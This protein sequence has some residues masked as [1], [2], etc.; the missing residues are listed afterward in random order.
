MSDPGRRR[1]F[2]FVILGLLSAVG[3]FSI[4]MYLPAFDNIATNLD[5]TVA[6]IQYSLT[7]FFIG[8]SS[9]QLV[10]GPLLDRFGRKPPL[11]VG[12]VIYIAA[13][14]GCALTNSADHLIVYRFIQALGSCSGLVASRAMVRDFFGP[15]ESA[16][17]FSLLMLVIGISPILAPS[18]GG[19]VMLHWDWHGI[20]LIL[21]GITT[22]ILIAVVFK[23]PESHRPNPQLSLLPRHII[24]AYWQVFRHRQF[25]T[26]ALAGGLASSGLYAYLAG[27][28][29]LMITKYGLS[30]QQ[31]GLVFGF[32]ASALIAASQLNRYVLKRFTSAFLAKRALTIQSVMGLLLV[33]FSVAGWMNAYLM[34]GLVFLFVGSQ[35]F[36]FPNTSA[37]ALAPFSE[38][39]GS[40]S[41][42][43]GS[44]Q[45]AIGAIS[46]GAVSYLH[47]ETAIPMTS[48]MAACATLSFLI[49]L[50][51]SPRQ[52]DIRPD[53]IR[54]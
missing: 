50:I 30:Q 48:V 27:S 13:S 37:L 49:V 20:F 47:N 40:A 38:L 5:T 21:T 52:A 25:F 24:N 7:S 12:L 14:L 35:G 46:S 45:M 51:S 33:A 34:V 2:I 26:Y 3:P 19:F 6:H 8:I 16:R 17:I 54:R 36:I 4:D 42:L 11:I 32:I 43:L 29:Y 41:A 15:A 1:Q 9:G 28:P 31:Y 39:A 22:L 23:L 53:Q 18:V 44:L 10:Y